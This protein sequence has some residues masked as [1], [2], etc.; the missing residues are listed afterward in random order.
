VRVAYE[1]LSL[2]LPKVEFDYVYSHTIHIPTVLLPL[3]DYPKG[4]VQDENV[5]CK[6]T[7]IGWIFSGLP[8]L[9]SLI[10]L[11][12]S[13]ISVYLRVRSTINKLNQNAAGD[14]SRDQR[15]RDVATQA[16][17]YVVAC[18]ISIIW[19]VVVRTLESMGVGRDDEQS[20]FWL[21]L[22]TQIFFPAQGLW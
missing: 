11:I 12:C 19:M 22:L 6:S 17:L 3:G 4:C 5:P 21:L 9:G 18:F 10:F 20:V 13:N 14:A 2:F 15:K 8:L 7:M 16:T 1:F